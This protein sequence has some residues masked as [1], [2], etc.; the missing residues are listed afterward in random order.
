MIVTSDVLAVDEHIR[1]SPLS[2]DGQ[3]DLLHENSVE[4]CVQFDYLHVNGFH[5]IEKFL[6]GTAMGAITFSEDDDL[7]VVNKVLDDAGNSLCL[8][9]CYVSFFCFSF[10]V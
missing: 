2:C 8:S 7:I 1:Y 10:V 6:G 5:G 3:E 9:C 4:L